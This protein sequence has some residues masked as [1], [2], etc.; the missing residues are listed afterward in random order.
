MKLFISHSW[1]DKTTAGLLMQDLEPMVEVWL[2]IQKLRPGNLE[3]D[4][5]G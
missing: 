3:Q 2:D 4:L 5:S 1:R